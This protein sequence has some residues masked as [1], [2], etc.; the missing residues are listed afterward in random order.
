MSGFIYYSVA[1]PGGDP[2]PPSPPPSLLKLVKKK[3]A[4]AAGR[5]F[6]KSSDPPSDKFLDPLLLLIET[7]CWCKYVHV[8]LVHVYQIFSDSKF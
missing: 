2:G 4:A 5:K 7:S 1:D 3:M 8:S 6:R